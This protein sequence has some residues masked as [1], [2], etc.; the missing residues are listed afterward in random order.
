LDV[1]LHTVIKVTPTPTGSGCVVEFIPL[2]VPSVNTA[3][4]RGM[5]VRSTIPE[6][7]P[8]EGEHSQGEH[9]DDDAVFK[10]N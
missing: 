4:A 6:E 2:G 3:R 10:S 7:T 8:G 1:P 5:S 9:S